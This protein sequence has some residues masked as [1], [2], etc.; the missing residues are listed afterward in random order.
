M[1]AWAFVPEHLREA[2]GDTKA[3]SPGPEGHHNGVKFRH[4]GVRAQQLANGVRVGLKR[5][6]R[7]SAQGNNRGIAAKTGGKGA[8]RGTKIACI[9]HVIFAQP[10]TQTRAVD[11]VCMYTWRLGPKKRVDIQ[12]PNG[13]EG[14]GGEHVV[15]ARGAAGQ[16]A[17]CTA[18]LCVVK[19]AGKQLSCLVPAD[20]RLAFRVVDEQE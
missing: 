15:T 11:A 14:R 8:K 13:T 6:G 7:G 1:Y 20:K 10:E 5:R 18:G 19:K 17:A 9:L 16:K 3:R 2:E 12:V 4:R